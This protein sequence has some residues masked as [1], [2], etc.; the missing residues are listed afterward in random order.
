MDI[1]KYKTKTI[2]AKAT[3]K[4]EDEFKRIKG[5]K[6]RAAGN[7]F[8]K[9]VREDLEKKGWIV[10][11][12]T[13]NVQI[14]P[15]LPKMGIIPAKPKFVFN[16]QLKR[17]V[18]IG[19]SS[20]FPDFIAFR[21]KYSLK[22]VNGINPKNNEKYHVQECSMGRTYNIQEIIGVESKMDGRLDK[23]EKLKCQWLL[24]NKVFTKI[25]IARKG[26]KRGE[27]K[28]QEF[29]KIFEGLEM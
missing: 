26:E 29:E 11:K 7:R 14:D 6:S 20:G 21:L 17:R 18:M 16:P 19:N 8:E 15:T 4:I 12:W 24:K 13:N 28:Y 9:R 5:K 25:L 27:I 3:T 1:E 10:D 22:G 2:H 23:Q